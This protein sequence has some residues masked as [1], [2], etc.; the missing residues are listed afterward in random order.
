ME[1]ST[2]TRPAD[3]ADP[4]PTGHGTEVFDIRPGLAAATEPAVSAPQ[5]YA[6]DEE[7]EYGDRAMQMLRRAVAA[8]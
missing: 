3:P 6:L 4:T 5:G 8:G 7:Q 2:P 1:P